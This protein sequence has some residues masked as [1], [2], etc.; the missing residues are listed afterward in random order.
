MV[1]WHR[2]DKNRHVKWRAAH[3]GC[4]KAPLHSIRFLFKPHHTSKPLSKKHRKFLQRAT[5]FFSGFPLILNVG[6][7]FF[8]LI[9]FASLV[10][11]ARRFGASQNFC[12]E[13]MKNKEREMHVVSKMGFSCFSEAILS[14][15]CCMHLVRKRL[16]PGETRRCTN[17]ISLA[18][19]V[20]WFLYFALS[21]FLENYP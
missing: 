5:Y 6:F 10:S 12:D 21:F 3:D 2:R 9:S 13:A 17:V 15:K 4:N 8:F 11:F 16:A 20:L 18:F 1:L 19:T 7:R 14:L